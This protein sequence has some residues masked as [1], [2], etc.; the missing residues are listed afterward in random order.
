MRPPL[1]HADLIQPLLD[2]I[3]GELIRRV[4]QLS[5]LPMREI[6]QDCWQRFLAGPSAR[7]VR[8][9]RQVVARI[10]QDQLAL[11]VRSADRAALELIHDPDDPPAPDDAVAPDQSLPPG[12]W[13]RVQAAVLGIDV[14]YRQEAAA[15]RDWQ[16]KVRVY[17][18]DDRGAVRQ[19]THEIPVPWD[20]LPAE[21]RLARIAQGV[22][23]QRFVLHGERTSSS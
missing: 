13:E 8:E 5:K 6:V 17:L 14:I 12:D 16:R 20:A 22:E 10:L 15:T 3:I 23:E 21:V 9:M 11:P 4:P 2:A 18:R 1:P 19:V 7:Q